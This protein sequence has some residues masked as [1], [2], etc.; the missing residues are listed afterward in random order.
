MRAGED[1]V[2]E[3][4]AVGAKEG[5]E[6]AIT[7]EMIHAGVEAWRAWETSDAWSIPDFVSSLYRAMRVLEPPHRGMPRTEFDR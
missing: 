5:Q 6:P 1:V 4:S 7:P 2:R 3:D